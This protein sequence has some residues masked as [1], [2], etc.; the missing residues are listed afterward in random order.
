[1]K[2]RTIGIG[3]ASRVQIGMEFEIS[4]LEARDT[5]LFLFR[6]SLNVNRKIKIFHFRRSFKVNRKIKMIR[7][8]RE[9]IV[10]VKFG[11]TNFP[12]AFNPS[13]PTK[14]I[15]DTITRRKRFLSQGFLGNPNRSEYLSGTMRSFN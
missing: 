4:S 5:F 11:K 13:V 12:L 15:S 9:T 8:L 1:M 2:T 7:T 14:H 3:V 10:L 6:R